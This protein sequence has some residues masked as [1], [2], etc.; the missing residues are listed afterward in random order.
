VVVGTVVATLV[1]LVAV[2]VDV[3]SEV[4]AI[5]A[6]L[7]NVSVVDVGTAGLCSSP[8][9]QPRSSGRELTPASPEDG[10]A[11][12]SNGPSRHVPDDAGSS[13]TRRQCRWTASGLQRR[14]CG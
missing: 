12:V 4:V 7:G 9:P 5:V 1:L 14:L 3:G 6:I 11:S 10:Q 8:L 2:V 13:P